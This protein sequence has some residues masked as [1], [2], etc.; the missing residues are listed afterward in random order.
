MD[1]KQLNTRFSKTSHLSFFKDNFESNKS[2]VFSI[3]DADICYT[4]TEV[5]EILEQYK[6][7]STSILDSNNDNQVIEET[8][9]ENN[10]EILSSSSMSD[11]ISSSEFE[12]LNGKMKHRNEPSDIYFDMDDKKLIKE[13]N[14]LLSRAKNF[15]IE[16]FYYKNKLPHRRFTLSGLYSV[17][18]G[19]KTDKQ[20]YSIREL[21]RIC[22]SFLKSDHIQKKIE[23]KMNG[24][25]KERILIDR[26]IA[27]T[28]L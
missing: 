18:W 28:I 5:I 4:L 16:E 8:I 7:K 17:K 2:I 10:D 9:S 12:N 22:N 25:E 27:S 1:P 6:S 19:I 11:S 21:C 20:R 26:K 15:D 14:S 13:A 23:Y 24:L 3:P